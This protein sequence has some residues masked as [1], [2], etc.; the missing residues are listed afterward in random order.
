MLETVSALFLRADG[1]VLLG[2]RA[3]WKRAWADHWDAIGGRVEQDEALD[4]ALV[5]ECREE[6]GLT[7]TTYRLMLSA[8]E[9]FPAR[10]GA[11]LHHI[12]VVSGWDGGEAENLTDEHVRIGW[13]SLDEM[14]ALPNLTVPDLIAVVREH[15][16][17]R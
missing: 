10:N 16:A 7:P 9:R 6:V 8:E 1:R 15:A 17:A 11:A 4:A 12:Y 3:S 13:F 5:R 2:L 14:A